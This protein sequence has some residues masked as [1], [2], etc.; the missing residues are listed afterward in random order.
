MKKIA[1]LATA[2][3]AGL[4]FTSTASAEVSVS[5]SQVLMYS[6]AGSVTNLRN[7]GT[8]DF[9]LSTTT[10]SGMTISS[11]AGISLGDGGVAA[12]TADITSYG[13]DG[14]TFSTGGATI[15]IGTDVALADGVGEVDGIH[16]SDATADHSGMK[17][18]SNTVGIG[19]TDEG[20]GIAFTTAMG[21]ATLSLAYVADMDSDGD[22]SERIDDA[23]ATGMSAK[24]STTMGAVGVTAAYV[25]ADPA[26]GANQ[27]ET[28]ASLSYDTGMGS[29]TVGY[30]S[31]T[32]A[33]ANKGHV[34]SAAYKYAL[35]ADTSLAV[36]YANYNVNSTSATETNFSLVRS[37]GGGASVFA[38]FATVSGS[39]VD[40][41]GNINGTAASAYTATS[42]VAVGT[43]VAF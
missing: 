25:S 16:A 43:K 24:I 26:S 38:D 23:T 20:T 42:V 8:L 40:T 27:S 3:L 2:V 1:Y 6:A 17:Q 32:G 12:T 9:G 39:G 7:I 31:S 21:G 10:A 5:G 41:N 37:L 14:L 15:E 28:A 35:D 13:F 29:V 22:T 4:G 33:A 19:A 34:L 18:Q 36:G 30:G 11:G